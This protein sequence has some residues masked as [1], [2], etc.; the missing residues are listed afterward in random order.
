MK[1][2]GEPWPSAELRAAVCEDDANR[3]PTPVGEDCTLCTEQ[4]MQD[5][6]GVILAHLSLSDE[7]P[8]ETKVE[9]RAAHVDCLVR[10]VGGPSAKSGTE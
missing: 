5:D 9:K 10:S 1:W 2:F 6:Q 7:D 3:V 4:I 8:L